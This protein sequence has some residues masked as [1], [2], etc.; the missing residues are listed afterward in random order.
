MQK[1]GGVKTTTTITATG[2]N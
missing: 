2:E 1:V